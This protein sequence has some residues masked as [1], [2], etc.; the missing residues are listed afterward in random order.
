MPRG[1]LACEAQGADA[2]T[3]QLVGHH[4]SQDEQALDGFMSE[5]E[6]ELG[7]VDAKVQQGDERHG[8]EGPRENVG[9][10]VPVERAGGAENAGKRREKKM[11]CL[12]CV[13][14]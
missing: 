13:R 14:S 9:E 2:G 8:D 1:L 6:V 12:N 11:V 10:E 7:A 4:R 5:E 3:G